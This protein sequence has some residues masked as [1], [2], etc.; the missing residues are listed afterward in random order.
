MTCYAVT[1]RT[2]KR[3]ASRCVKE[4]ERD[5]GDRHRLIIAIPDIILLPI[6]QNRL[7]DGDIAQLVEHP[8]SVRKVWGSTPHVSMFFRTTD[9]YFFFLTFVSGKQ[10]FSTQ[11][12]RWGDQLKTSKVALCLRHMHFD[13]F[14]PHK[15]KPDLPL[16]ATASKP[17]SRQ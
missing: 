9:P 8:L 10:F 5:P 13:S 7:V 16:G 6:L 4:D 3:R 11:V 1:R 12:C 14:G 15:L 2:R 17:H